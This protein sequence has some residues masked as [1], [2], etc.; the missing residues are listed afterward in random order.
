MSAIQKSDPYLMPQEYL[1]REREAESKSEYFN[2]HVV[3]MAGATY[4]HNVIAVNALISIGR[5][6]RG[7]PCVALGSDMKV[8]VEKANLF[9][10][11]DLSAVCGPI[12]FYDSHQDVYCNPAFILEVLAPGTE[13]YDRTDKFALYRLVDSFREYVLVA[14]DRIEIEV[15][16]REP[17]GR[18]SATLFNDRADVAR[19]ESI[20][21]DLPL[22]DLFEKIE[23]S[24]H[25]EK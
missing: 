11:P 19:L 9:R 8:R 4:W 16:R 13:R 3:E 10:Y 20:G 23:M 15:H 18:W 22:A 1:V 2:G 6:C 24:V 17:D 25:P 21:C 5:Q 7:R 14:Q 12:D